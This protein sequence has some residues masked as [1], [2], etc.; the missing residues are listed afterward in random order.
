MIFKFFGE[1]K[2]DFFFVVLLDAQE[3]QSICL[4]AGL[5][6]N[7]DMPLTLLLSD[8]LNVWTLHCLSN[9]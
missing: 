3:D 7:P 1:K 9:L 4:C 5:L 2:I 6:V 8:T